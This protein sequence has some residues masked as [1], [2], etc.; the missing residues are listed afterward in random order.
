[1]KHAVKK[2]FPNTLIEN[3]PILNVNELDADG[4]V[5]F[6]KKFNEILDSI[7]REVKQYSLYDFYENG[8]IDDISVSFN[9]YSE[10]FYE[11]LIYVSSGHVLLQNDKKEIR[12]RL[13]DFITEKFKLYVDVIF[14]H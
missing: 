13:S 12:E 5:V 2:I 3:T 9:F 7:K 10:Y 11:L 14:D 8:D 1:M 4:S 6:P